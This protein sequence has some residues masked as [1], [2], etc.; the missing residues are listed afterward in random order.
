V[1]P[2]AAVHGHAHVGVH[3]IAGEIPGDV[4]D[5]ARREEARAVERTPLHH[6][7]VEGGHGPGGGVAAAPRRA[8]AV[9]GGVVLLRPL[10]LPPPVGRRLVHVHGPRV[11]RVGQAHEEIPAQSQRL[12]H[13][14]ADEGAIVRLG[15][16][17]DED[18]RRPVRGAA[19]VVH[20]RA[21]S[22]LEREA[23]HGLPQEIVVLPRR[24]RHVGIGI[25][26]LVRQELD[27]RDLA[28]AIGLE[29]GDVIGHPVGEAQSAAL[30]EG[31][32]R[33]GGDDLGI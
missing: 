33:A 26:G 19:V 14:L 17:L 29:A 23:A 20:A 3:A 8:R 7:L 32:H 15:E 13:V 21:G 10:A 4:L 1:R 2:E 18:G 16:R 27:D 12:D 6:H 11:V 9:E 30:D 25:A 5:H 22:E 28:L 31:P 24:A